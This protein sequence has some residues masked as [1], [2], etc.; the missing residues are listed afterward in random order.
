MDKLTKKRQNRVIFQQRIHELRLKTLHLT[1]EVCRKV[2]TQKNREPSKTD[3][4]L[5][6]K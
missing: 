4:R 5:S 6:I 2:Y 3:S 1:K